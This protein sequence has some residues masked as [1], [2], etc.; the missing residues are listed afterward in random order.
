MRVPSPM[1]SPLRWATLLM[2]LVLKGC[3]PA[4]LP[5]EFPDSSPASPEAA[6]LAAPPVER[7]L[8]AELPLPYEDEGVFEGLLPEVDEEAHRRHHGHHLHH[9]DHGHGD[10][11]G[12]HGDHGHHLH[13]GD[14]GHGDAHG[15]HGAGT[16]DA[17]PHETSDAHDESASEPPHPRE[18]ALDPN[19]EGAHEKR[20]SEAPE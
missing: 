5:H 11:H 8:I 16:K 12:H 10:A 6:L 9:G 17:H 19:D 20:P 2:P 7:A 14:H 15:H 1:M 4:A 13:H 3:A 18:G